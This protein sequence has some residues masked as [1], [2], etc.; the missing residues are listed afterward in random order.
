MQFFDHVPF[1]HI[2]HLRPPLCALVD[3]T[4]PQSLADFSLSGE[5]YFAISEEFITASDTGGIWGCGGSCV[6][7][8]ALPYVRTV[9]IPRFY[10]SWLNNIQ[11]QR[12]FA[13]DYNFPPLIGASFDWPRVVINSQGYR[14]ANGSWQNIGSMSA[15]A[16]WP[17]N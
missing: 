11:S 8:S 5:F 4:L 7:C 17:G 12:Y 6:T 15:Q 2:Q 10:I 13:S 9:T 1:L 14:Y 16:G 3:Y